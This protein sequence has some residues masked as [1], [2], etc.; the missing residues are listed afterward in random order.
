MA[1]SKE[2]RLAP[3]RG[4]S[5]A[6]VRQKLKAYLALCGLSAP[7]FAHLID[8][9]EEAMHFFLQARYVK[10]ASTDRYIAEESWLYMQAHPISPAK[11]H[12]GRRFVT[13]DGERIRQLCLRALEEKSWFLIEG[14]PGMQKSYELYHFFCERNRSG[15][16]DAA[17]VYG[18]A[19]MTAS[20][21]LFQIAQGLDARLSGGGSRDRLMRNLLFNFAARPE[22]PLVIV[23]E[24][25]HLVPPYSSKLTAV[26]ILRELGD[27]AGCGMILGGSHEFDR[28]LRNGSGRYLQQWHRRL[29]IERLEGLR[30][31]EVERIANEELGRDVSAK[32]LKE[33]VRRCRE[34]CYGR[35][36]Y[37]CGRLVKI[38]AEIK[39]KA[40]A[41]TNP[42]APVLAGEP[43]GRAL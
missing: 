39:R 22:P 41:E 37:S 10:I 2:R 29:E 3:R 8:Y 25:Q 32:F 18:G 38:L 35:P 11:L 28:T 19:Q 7:D 24:A 36:Y 5:S 34:D 21:L 40:L 4:P 1:V 27:R 31:D 23:D 12:S 17:F 26:E 33:L 15:K 16:R 9:S 6:I 13:R 43:E 30:P 20:S 42:P 14:G